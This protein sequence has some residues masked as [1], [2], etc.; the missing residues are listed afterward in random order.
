MNPPNK[1]GPVGAASIQSSDVAKLLPK[2]KAKPV[3]DP[4]L[5][6]AAEQFEE[7]FVKQILSNAKLTGKDKEDGYDGM[8]VDAVASAVS[9][10]GGLGLAHQIEEAI[11]RARQ[12]TTK[13]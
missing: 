2:A 9:K 8:A 10:G 6:K 13:K 4:K 11:S 1:I 3:I 7:M 12:A 5:K